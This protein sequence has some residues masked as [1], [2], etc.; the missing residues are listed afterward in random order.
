VLYL[1]LEDPARRLK[2]RL[3]TLLGGSQ[4]PARLT[5]WTVCPPLPEG[6]EAAI[7]AW[8]DQHPAARLVVVD[9]FTRVRGEAPRGVSAFAADYRAVAQVKAIADDYGVAVVLVHHDRK[10]PADDFLATIS[11]TNGLAAAA[12]TILVLK[13]ARGEADAVLHAIGRDVEE[14]ERAL[15]FTPAT[16]AWVLLRGPVI[17]FT[18]T[19]VR[20]DV[21]RWLRQHGAAKPLEIADALD[22]KP[23]TVRQTCRRMA[24]EGDLGTDGA[25]RYWALPA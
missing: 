14:V 24:E 8:L 10:A 7:R 15:R 9:V 18:A 16:G 19:G 3:A 23:N 12:D 4:P 2:S 17:D 22:L 13:R 1:A 6:G 5:I 20:G 21:L 11:G 25:G